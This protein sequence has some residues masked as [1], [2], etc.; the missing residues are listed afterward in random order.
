MTI[1]TKYTIEPFLIDFDIYFTD[2]TKK[3]ARKLIKANPSPE[4]SNELTKD[5]ISDDGAGAS[6]AAGMMGIKMDTYGI[7]AI[8]DID[9]IK[10]HTYAYFTHES[11][12]ILSYILIWTGAKYDPLNDE[13]TSYMLDYIFRMIEETYNKV[14]L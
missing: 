9:S 1:H 8:F 6:V 7:I 4:V 12:H 14:N 11:G 13:W 5:W 3:L 2:D 10:E